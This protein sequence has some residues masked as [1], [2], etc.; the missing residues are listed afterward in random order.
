MGG[1]TEAKEAANMKKKEENSK[2]KHLIG[3]RVM[4]DE[5]IWMKAGVVNFRICDNTYD[6]YTCPFDKGMQRAMSSG[7]KVGSKKEEYGWTAHLIANHPGSVRPCRYALT[8]RIDAPKICPTN[9]ECYHCAFDQMMD[10]LDFAQVSDAPQ[11]S[12]ASGYKMAD[13]YYYHTG[14]CWVRFEHG[15]RVRVGFDDFMV[16]LFGRMQSITLPLPGS[17]L[18]K[19]EESITFSRDDHKAASLSPATGTVLAV[20]Q[21][22]R[23]HPEI[24]HED[25]FHKGWLYILE[26]DMPKRN[27]KGLYYGKDSMRWMEQE[28]RKLL[29]LVGPGYERLAATGAEPIGDVIG[30]FPELEWDLLVKTFLRTGA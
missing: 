26:P 27:L 25:P 2:K 18:K 14:H 3:F 16:K 24:T 1:Y 11:Y 21:N 4:E 20:N 23:E 15:G 10:D 9:Y 30:N 17:E 22:A 12:L 8:G 6:C 13:G 5:C 7:E 29:S 19:D 28:S